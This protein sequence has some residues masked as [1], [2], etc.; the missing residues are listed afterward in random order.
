MGTINTILAA[1]F[2]ATAPI[3]SIVFQ[4]PKTESVASSIKLGKETVSSVRSGYEN[5]I[6][7][8]FLTEMD[9]V[10]KEGDLGGLLQMRQKEVPAT[11]QEKWEEKFLDLQKERNDQ[12]LSIISD[13]D[14]TVFAKKVRSLAANLLTPEQEK[15]LSKLNGFIAMAP[16]SGANEDENT[17]I[18]IDLEYEYKLLHAGYPTSD[19]SPEKRGAYQLALRMEKMDKMVAASKNFEDASLK[20]AVG[21]AAAS[22]DERLARNL[23]GVDLNRLL[24]AKAKPSN[25]TEEAVYSVLS[26]YQAK[27]TDLMKQIDHANQ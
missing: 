5:G 7:N 1:C 18:D 15:A 4:D 25:A 16:G 9:A 11:F 10:Y 19:V 12:L 2:C 3:S 14:D 13:K 24:K 27:F 23:D 20:Q 26:S 22:L 6:Y 21:I 17:L 8:E